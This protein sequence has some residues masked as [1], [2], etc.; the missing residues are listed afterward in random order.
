MESLHRLFVLVHVIAGFSALSFGLAAMLTA[1]GGRAHRFSGKVY[2]WA[3]AVSCFTAA[4]I[5]ALFNKWFFFFLA[6]ISFESAARGYRII[7]RKK[8][9]A[10]QPPKIA[11]W[12]LVII[13]AAMGAGLI[14]WGI[15]IMLA[16]GVFGIVAFIFGALGIFVSFDY[17]KTFRNS[18]PDPKHWM[19][20]H[21][22]GMAVSYI[23]AT[24]AFL[25]NNDNWFPFIPAIWLW[26]LPTIIGVPVM[27]YVAKNR[28]GKQ[29]ESGE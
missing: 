23:A 19:R 3:M 27:L 8:G 28:A 9:G 16:G 15:R 17:Y 14:G 4:V 29:S 1:K 12:L 11:D 10:E 26:L 7:Y 25:V 20:M 5:G 22:R 13:N 21:I 6:F 2:F 18:A 24:T